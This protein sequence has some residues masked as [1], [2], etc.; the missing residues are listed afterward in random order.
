MNMYTG[1]QC[2]VLSSALGE[3]CAEYT[4][5]YVAHSCG[6][7]SR[8]SRRVYAPC[9]SRKRAHAAAALQDDARF[10]LRRKLLR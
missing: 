7:H 10:E 6:R 2:I 4:G 9:S 5:Q 8:I 1:K 3:E